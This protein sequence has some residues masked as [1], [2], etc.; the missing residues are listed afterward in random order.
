MCVSHD[1]RHG[2][3]RGKACVTTSWHTFHYFDRISVY[4]DCYIFVNHCHPIPS[5]S[6]FIVIK[7]QTPFIIL[8]RN[9][10]QI[11][12]HPYSFSLNSLQL[13][14]I[15]WHSTPKYGLASSKYNGMIASGEPNAM[16]W[17]MEARSALS[18][19]AVASQGWLMFCW[20]YIGTLRFS[21]FALPKKPNNYAFHASYP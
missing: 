14:H 11:F 13:L 3:I 2:H 8:H 7:S 10:F 20:Q 9:E 12:Y 17:F 18:F 19:P 4:W 16:I 15:H 6:V 21:S 1:G 5:H